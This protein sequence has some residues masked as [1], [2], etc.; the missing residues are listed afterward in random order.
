MVLITGHRR[1]NFGDGFIRISKA[2][3]ELTQKYSDIDFIY[4]MHLNP[5]VRKPIHEV[6]GDDL[7]NLNNMFFIEPLEYLSFVYLMEKSTLVLTDSG[8]VQEEAPW[9]WKTC[10][11]DARYNGTTGSCFSR[12]CATCWYRL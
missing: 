9:T 10:I 11:G 6:F 3:K 7:S 2:I 5:N 8:G 12:N 4:P 1:E